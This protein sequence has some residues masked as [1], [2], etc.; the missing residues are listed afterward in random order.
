MLPVA[1]NSDISQIEYIPIKPRAGCMGFV[2][3]VLNG[4]LYCGSVA[5]YSRPEG[6]I[7]LVWP[8]VNNKGVQ[9]PTVHPINQELTQAIERAVRERVENLLPT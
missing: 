5:V 8:K 1:M 4:N 7:R 6:G 9:Y 3:F 2:S